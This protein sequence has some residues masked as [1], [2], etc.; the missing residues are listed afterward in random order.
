MTQSIFVAGVAIATVYLLFR[1]IEMRF[2][3]KEKKPLKFLIRDTLMVYLSVVIGNFILSQFSS[4]IIEQKSP[5]VF[6]DIPNF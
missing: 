6:T 3:L 5:E 1:F 4:S 2:I